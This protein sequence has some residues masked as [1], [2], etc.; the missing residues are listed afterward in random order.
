VSANKMLKMKF[1]KIRPVSRTGALII[2][3]LENDSFKN[4]LYENGECVITY[5]L[6]KGVKDIPRLN[7]EN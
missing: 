5:F 4:Y 1:I 3:E 7:A 6:G 2:I